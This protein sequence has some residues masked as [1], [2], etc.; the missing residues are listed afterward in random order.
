MVPN[1]VNTILN[2]KELLMVIGVS[3]NSWL[4]QR[5]ALFG[6]QPACV[7]AKARKP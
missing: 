6:V 1:W 4:H 5:K 3:M 7:S 2:L